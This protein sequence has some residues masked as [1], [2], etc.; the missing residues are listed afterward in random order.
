MVCSDLLFHFLAGMQYWSFARNNWRNEREDKNKGFL[1][2]LLQLTNPIFWTDDVMTKISKKDFSLKQKLSI[3][4]FLWHCDFNL[5]CFAY[6]SF[7]DYS[8][9]WQLYVNVISLFSTIKMSYLKR[10]RIRWVLSLLMC[11]YHFLRKLIICFVYI[12]F[13][14]VT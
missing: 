7:F 9:M 3:V 2:T 13:E 11:Q 14:I 10:W 1:L 12:N 8:Y 4:R 6:I 5:N